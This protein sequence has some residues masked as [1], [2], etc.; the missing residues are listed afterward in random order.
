MKFN[1]WLSTIVLLI[2]VIFQLGCGTYQLKSQWLDRE[3][4][5]DGNADDWLGVKYYFEEYQVAVGFF[6][7]DRY[8]Y[9]GFMA[10]NPMLL[11]QI[12]RQGLTLWIDP[13]GKK[14]KYFGICFP[15]PGPSRQKRPLPD[16]ASEL[17]RAELPQL[18]AQ[19]LNELEIVGPGDNQVE[20]LFLSDLTGIKMAV[21]PSAGMLVY[22]LK[23][24]F[25]ADENNRYAVGA[26]PGD[27]ISIGILSPKLNFHSV[28]KRKPGGMAGMGARGGGRPGGMAGR[29][30][31]GRAGGFRVPKDLKIWA[32][33][34][35]ALN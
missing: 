5:I 13:L 27:K 9:M 31:P 17:N 28:S 21:K 3:I 29:R 24:P 2:C 6:N 34:Q 19:S 7:D 22:E 26:E 25:E 4:T 18:F 30:I 23:I 14:N 1:H 8:L 33:L 32:T 10:E 11:V 16:A 15:L 12:M 35:L 20:R